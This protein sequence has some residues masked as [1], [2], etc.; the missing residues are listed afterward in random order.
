[1]R[2]ETIE[3]S[4]DGL[5]MRGQAIWPTLMTVEPPYPAVIV[6]HA[7]S[8]CSDF[9]QGQAEMLAAMGFIGFAADMYGEGEVV[10]SKEEAMEKMQPLLADRGPL[11][12]RVQA[13]LEM[14]AKLPDVD[15]ERIAA[16]GYC[17]GG[18]TVLELARSGAK[19]RGVVS[20][21]GLLSPDPSMV[22]QKINTPVLVLHGEADPMIPPEQVLAFQQEMN[23]A[24][25]DWQLHS[26][27]GV[28]HSF[29][30]P[31]VNSP[32]EGSCYN[33]AA[34]RRSW[35]AMSNFLEEVLRF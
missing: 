11:R 27:G 6:C 5:T 14:A 25:T 20:F 19:L 23:E 12:L 8:G 4:A 3:Y 29:T 10:D 26:Y 35:Q 21:H 22:R 1:M 34:A 30:N 2:K 9:E 7:Y 16:I 31:N 15:R 28:M 24:K 33:E 13:A 32:E 17:F 18:A